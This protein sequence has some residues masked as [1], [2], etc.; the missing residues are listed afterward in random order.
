MSSQSRTVDLQ[1][2]QEIIRRALHKVAK[3]DDVQKDPFVLLVIMGASLSAVFTELHA[4]GGALLDEA[5]I[6]RST[7]AATKIMGDMIRQD[8][9]GLMRHQRGETLQ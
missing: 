4:Q 3:L 8:M 7:A 2:A 9:T 5:Q 1:R 6:E